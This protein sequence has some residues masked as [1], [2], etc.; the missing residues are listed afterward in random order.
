[1]TVKPFVLILLFAFLFLS[2]ESFSQ[3][4]SEQDDTVKYR[5]ETDDGNV[6][7]GSIVD[8]K[9]GYILLKT[10]NIGMITVQFDRIVKMERI[11]SLEQ[12]EGKKRMKEYSR[13]QETTYHFT[14]NGYGLRKGEGYYQNSYLFIN[15]FYVGI[16]DYFSLGGGLVPVPVDGTPVWVTPKFSVPIVKDK[17]NMGVGS[18]NAVTLGTDSESFGMFYTNVT[19]GSRERNFSIGAGKGYNDGFEEGFAFSVSGAYKLG[20][21]MYLITEN[22]AISGISIGTVGGRYVW[23]GVSAE[24]SIIYFYE[25]D[26]FIPIPY[27]GMIVPFGHSR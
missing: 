9:P 14:P 26:Y 15:Q 13:P 1:M 12:K 11:T 2:K 20:E 5:I 4:R 18:V 6:Y 3:A 8:Q 21:N 17:I 19:F 16:T 25:Y 10:A 27:I 23:P 22:Y 24:F 7:M